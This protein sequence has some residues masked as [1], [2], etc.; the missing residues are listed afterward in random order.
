[1]YLIPVSCNVNRL[2]WPSP[3]IPAVF[4]WSVPA[5][6]SLSLKRH[7]S[8]SI[9]DTTYLLNQMVAVKRKRTI[10]PAARTFLCF[11]LCLVL[12][13]R[14]PI[15]MQKK[16]F[17]IQTSCHD[18]FRLVITGLFVVVAPWLARV[19]CSSD[20]LL[21][22]TLRDVRSGSSCSS[23]SA[24]TVIFLKFADDISHTCSILA[25]TLSERDSLVAMSLMFYASDIRSFCHSCPS[26]FQ[27]SLLVFF[28]V[29]FFVVFACFS[30][31]V[32]FVCWNSFHPTPP[33]FKMRSSSFKRDLLS[34][35]NWQNCLRDTFKTNCR[36]FLRER[37]ST[38]LLWFR[39]FLRALMLPSCP[40]TCLVDLRSTKT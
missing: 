19:C 34:T 29:F 23:S 3:S 4:S 17:S 27:F 40:L 8:V 6:T 20:L 16:W 10:R 18:H 2:S 22:V 30:F 35:V 37:S 11:S 7:F 39:W 1:M 9:T 24:L 13:P 36:S 15:F 14:I 38:Y 33:H 26:S 12:S 28:F 5:V 21:F 31:N 32:Q 25:S